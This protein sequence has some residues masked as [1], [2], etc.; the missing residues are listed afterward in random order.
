MK[1]NI[2]SYHYVIFYCIYHRGSRYRLRLFNELDDFYLIIVIGWYSLPLNTAL[3]NY[4]DQ[5]NRY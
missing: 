3:F 1:N 4:N 5:P 2:I